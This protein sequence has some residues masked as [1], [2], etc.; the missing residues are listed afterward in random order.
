MTEKVIL[1]RRGRKS[2]E[3][4]AAWFGRVLD[5]VRDS[6]AVNGDMAVSIQR[7]GHGNVRGGTGT[8][9]ESI[10]AHEEF[11]YLVWRGDSAFDFVRSIG[12]AGGRGA[13]GRSI[14]R[15]D[16][17]TGGSVFFRLGDS[18]WNDLG[19]LYAYRFAV[20]V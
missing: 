16:F 19:N 6:K 2:N 11:S 4:T 13:H 8:S 18:F 9:A 10:R 12:I 15:A 1:M 5:F 17:G 14:F 3:R 20:V 7:N